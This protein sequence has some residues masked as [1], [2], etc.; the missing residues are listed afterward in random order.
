MIFSDFPERTFTWAVYLA[1]RKCGY[2]FRLVGA[3]L[4]S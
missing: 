2:C 3:V 4:P 1:N